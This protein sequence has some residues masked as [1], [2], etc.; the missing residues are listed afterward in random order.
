[1]AKII[2]IDEM[3]IVAIKIERVL[4]NLGQTPYDPLREKKDED[5]IGKSF[6][7]K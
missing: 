4:R 6:T 3:V 7:N 1:V 5:T 2:D